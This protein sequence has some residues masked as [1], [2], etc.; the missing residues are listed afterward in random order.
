MTWEMSRSCLFESSVVKGR[1][2]LSEQQC[3]HILPVFTTFLSFVT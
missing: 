1:K 3:D 2:V